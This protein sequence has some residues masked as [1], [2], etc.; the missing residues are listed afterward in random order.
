MRVP[1]RQDGTAARQP[2]PAARGAGARQ[3]VRVRGASGRAGRGPPTGPTG[4]VRRR[5]GG[6]GRPGAA[7]DAS[8]EAGGGQADDDRAVAGPLAGQP[9]RHPVLHG[10]RLR[11]ARP[12]VPG[13]VS[14]PD[15]ARGP[16]GRACPGHVHRDHPA[17]GSPGQPGHSR[18]AEPD[19]G[20]AAGGAQR[21][22]PR[23][24]PGRQPG[25]RRGAAAG[26]P[27]PSGGVDR[28]TGAGVAADRRPPAGRGLAAGAHG[29]V[30][31]RHPGRPDV[32]GVSPH[33]A[34]RAAAR[35]GRRAAVV[36]CRP[37]RGPPR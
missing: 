25:M 17:A 2:V 8:A 14:R 4:R 22:D 36:R 20:D 23:W 24:V 12:A 18:H 19:Q 28:G 33:R 3:L 34:A 32:C 30:P 29:G 31:E 5:G 7:G 1:G 11:L 16:Q 10:A 13:P 35:R 9:D 27:A 37:R 6:A 15:P 26:P 21:R